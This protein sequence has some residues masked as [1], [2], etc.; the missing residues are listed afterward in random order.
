MAERNGDQDRDLGR[1]MADAEYANRMYYR[2]GESLKSELIA[3]AE[4]SYELHKG[5][6]RMEK[7]LESGSTP[8]EL[9]ERY[10]APREYSV[11]IERQENMATT[12]EELEDEG[13]AVITDRASGEGRLLKKKYASMA[14]SIEDV[15]VEIPLLDR[16]TKQQRVDESGRP[17]FKRVTRQVISFGTPEQRKELSE[18][19]AKAIKELEVRTVMGSQIGVRLNLDF[20]DNLEGITALLHGGRV[21]KFKP[22]HIEAL[23]NLPGLKELKEN[24]ENRRLGEQVEQAQFLNLVMLASASKERLTALL[25]RPGAKFLIA[26]MAKEKG[27]TYEEW[28]GENIGDYKNWVEDKDR[29]IKKTWRLEKAKGLRKGVTQ[30]SSIAAW[31][32][33]PGEFGND[34]ETDFIENVVGGAVGSEEAAWLAS[35]MMRVIGA[36]ASEG[37]V[38]LP[39]GKTLL[40]LGEGRYITGDDLGKLMAFMFNMKEGLAGRASGLSGMIG[41]IPD[42]E[43]NLFDWMQVEMDDLPLMRPDGRLPNKDGK[44]L[45][46]D[47]TLSD[48]DGTEIKQRRSVVD[49][50]LGTAEQPLRSV[51]DN[52]VMYEMGGSDTEKQDAVRNGTAKEFEIVDNKGVKRK[53]VVNKWVTE[54]QYHRLGSIN[55]NSCER[56]VHGTFSIMQWLDGN[57]RGPVGVFIDAMSVEYR[58]EDF[59]LNALKKKKKYIGIVMNPVNLTKGSPHLYGDAFTA[60]KTIQDNFL[61]NL[62]VARIHSSTFSEGILNQTIKL[63][64]PE[65]GGDAMVPAAVLVRAF[66]KE[67]LKDNPRD[68]EELKKHYIDE[69]VQLRKMGEKG[70]PGVRNDISA[71]LTE[72]FLP[73]APERASYPSGN[74]GQAQFEAAVRKYQRETTSVGIIRGKN[75]F[76]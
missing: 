72:D 29:D 31:Q 5:L 62:M 43:M 56:D 26:K 4:S 45:E 40:P 53:V 14:V 49:A 10:S 41:K 47:G 74:A 65:G 44:Y 12:I 57:E 16:R 69:N 66:V 67:V 50:W 17:R 75:Q 20:R 23:Y 38:A 2:S 58:Y 22:D 34:K 48:P 18:A 55:F 42:M 8:Q 15:E 68:E 70:T 35:T 1:E 37:F 24:P 36:Y 73:P 63:F 60:T 59:T 7:Q 46:D 21:S 71:L 39:G 54:E 19:Y 61:R 51:L 11:M 27:Q 28:V 76:T 32:G 52:S 33:N 30:W 13:I 6:R 3:T 64:N 25:E 9:E